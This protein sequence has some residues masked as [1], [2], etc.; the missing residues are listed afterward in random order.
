MKHIL[1]APDSFKGTLSALEVCTIET[2][3]IH[4]VF[5][6][7]S[8]TKLPVAD[9]GEG[10]TEAYL[11]AFGGERVS[12]AV[13]GP[14]GE[15]V[16]AVYVVL[17]DGTAVI[18]MAAAAGLPLM[19]GQPDPLHA[20]TYGV[21]ELLLDAQKRGAK[22]ILLGLGG[23]ATNDCGIG[24]AAALGWKFFDARGEEVVPLAEN[25]GRIADIKSPQEQF[26]LSVSAACDV[27][28]P[29][30][31]EQGATFVFGPQK[32]V[33]EVM[34]PKLEADMAHFAQVLKKTFPGFNEQTPGAGAAGGIG[35]AVKCF[36]HGALCP[37]IELLLDAAHFDELLAVADLVITGE[38]RMDAQSLHGKVP[39]GVGKR[40]QRAGKPCL[41][42]CGSLGKGAEALRSV[43]ITAFY[44][45]SDG[46]RTM[47]ELKKTCRDD[48]YRITAQALRELDE[49]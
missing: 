6:D 47:E 49:N 16:Q 36:L 10:M 17:P 12:C 26:S 5:P 23:S 15:T 31:G 14:N 8:V 43:G 1:L 41:A 28:N 20:T 3:A 35:S 11:S 46:R 30:L 9:G 18:E 24:M 45:A 2:E 38:G 33:P 27:N 40:A 42:V 25:L 19:R 13:R 39:C 32:G 44:A 29:L 37:G 21:G 7:A 34:K 4:S 48:L 22:R